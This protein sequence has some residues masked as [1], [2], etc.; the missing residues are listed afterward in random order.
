MSWVSVP[1]SCKQV[2]R[3]W[4]PPMKCHR[5]EKELFEYLSLP[6][7]LPV[8]CGTEGGSGRISFA[9][10]FRLFRSGREEGGR[11]ERGEFTIREGVN[12]RNDRNYGAERRPRRSHARSGQHARR[13]SRTRTSAGATWCWRV[14]ARAPVAHRR[15]APTAW[16]RH[17]K[18]RR[19]AVVRRRRSRRNV[20]GC[21]VRKRAGGGW[22]TWEPATPS[23]PSS[24][25]IV[26]AVSRVDL[27]VATC[28]VLLRGSWTRFPERG[29]ALA[30]L[31]RRLSFSPC[32]CHSYFLAYS[33][34]PSSARS[35]EDRLGACRS[36]CLSGSDLLR[37][38]NFGLKKSR[39]GVGREA[40]GVRASG[41]VLRV[42]ARDVSACVCARVS[43]C[44]CKAAYPLPLASPLL[45]AGLSLWPPCQWLIDLGDRS[46][47]GCRV[48]RSCRH[49]PPSSRRHPGAGKEVRQAVSSRATTR[50][51]LI[52]E[53]A[54][55]FLRES[56]CT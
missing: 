55:E 50:F 11:S 13:A 51:S 2:R 44:R 6:C 38:E 56:T 30:L 39:P 37:R 29:R 22:R 9:Q 15:G 21:T 19:D 1:V 35:P 31:R 42:F 3:K 16:R 25:M 4:E 27:S 20:A 41:D 5:R 34:S 7:N 8:D 48:A 12:P 33:S 49:P 24:S 52:K 43:P 18:R 40:A 47:H 17:E 32:L 53:R 28:I 10:I 46:S 36:P 54:I 26:G 14:H 45:V 23:S